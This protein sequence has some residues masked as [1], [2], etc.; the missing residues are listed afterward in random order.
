M[1]NG[2]SA[3]VIVCVMALMALTVFSCSKEKPEKMEKPSGH[4][5]MVE[6]Y[7]KGTE[8]LKK[9]VVARVNGVNIT[10]HDLFIR[11]D[12]L[13]QK[14]SR[15][16][17]QMTPEIRQQAQQEAL[18]LLVFRE[19]A[20]QEAARRKMEVPKQNVDSMLQQYKAKIGTEKEY[21][22]H[23][24]KQGLAET[25]VI[26]L[27]ERDQL[28][29]MITAREIFEKVKETGAGREQ[30]VEKRKRAWEQELKK[31]AKI[32]ILLTEAGKKTEEEAKNPGK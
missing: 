5:K 19:L 17:K 3:G 13:M 15:D 6:Q 14:Y 30:A 28:F 10:K 2:M 32:E 23:L 21:A 26:K 9:V 22:E 12:K 7:L 24:K 18:D 20:I 27:I 8:E 29:R 25:S 4:D 1:R 31:N 16:G 11:T